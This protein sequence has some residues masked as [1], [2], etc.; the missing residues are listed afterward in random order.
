[1]LKGL[2]MLDPQTGRGKTGPAWT[3]GAQVVEVEA[4]LSTC[5]YRVL[6]ASTAID[7]GKVINPELMR[8]MVAGGMAMGISMASPRGIH[9]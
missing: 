3:L 2:S 8:S 5:T 4:D 1:M 7:V 6:T 9:I